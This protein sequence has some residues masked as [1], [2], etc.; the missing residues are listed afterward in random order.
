MTPVSDG[1]SIRWSQPW[2]R[3]YFEAPLLALGLFAL[4]SAVQASAEPAGSLHEQP[5]IG[6]WHL[7]IHYQKDEGPNRDAWRWDDRVWV[8]EPRETLDKIEVVEPGPP[9]IDWSEHRLVNFHDKTGRFEA[10]RGGTLRVL[11]AWTPNAGQREEIETG[12]WV[13]SRGLRHKILNENDEAGWISRLPGHPQGAGVQSFAYVE[14]WRLRMPGGLPEFRQRGKLESGLS[15]EEALDIVY[16]VEEILASGEMR[17]RVIVE[18]YRNARFRLARTRLLTQPRSRDSRFVRQEAMEKRARKTPD[19]EAAKVE[20]DDG[21][22]ETI[23]L[24][25]DRHV[26][27]S[28]SLIL[29]VIRPW[30]CFGD[31]V[32]RVT[33]TPTGAEV[34]LSYVRRGTLLLYHS[35]ETPVEVQ[36]PSRITT[37][38]RDVVIIR[39]FH[40]GYERLEMRVPARGVEED[41]HFDLQPLENQVVKVAHAHLLGRSVFEITTSQEPI[42]R[43]NTGTDSHSV[44]IL[45][46]GLDA[47]IVRHLED[48][49]DPL[50]E[51]IQARQLADDLV[52][53]LEPAAPTTPSDIRV[54]RF[55]KPDATRDSYR[56]RVEF[57]RMMH[58]KPRVAQLKQALDTLAKAKA[59]PC[60]QVFEDELRG[61]VPQAALQ[62]NLAVHHHHER[63]LLR[64][65]LRRYASLQTPPSITTLDGETL[66]TG[67]PIE[68][69]MAVE[70]A[71][72]IH[73]FIA[74]LHQLA[75]LLDPTNEGAGAF[76]G[77]VLPDQAMDSF[78]P[79]YRDARQAEQRCRHERV[80]R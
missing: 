56:T 37:S 76:H 26:Q 44:V 27:D 41:I 18:G 51:T 72:E 60:D 63:A 75:A 31:R 15:E 77:L 1:V 43:F 17:G 64:E 20:E 49:E 71:P 46:T 35:G 40:A 34:G 12:L 36:I 73:G 33:T 10:V 58:E 28:T 9:A 70:H 30:H 16:R 45:R 3:T 59:D 13:S 74:W 54:R 22:P 65:A 19:A 5:F 25:P 11:V 2:F 39:A 21:D 38:D 52:M 47:E 80:T 23:E 78:A 24:I 55:V 7:L 4:S 50:F 32:F 79:I 48:V 53:R 29:S 42:L 67:H 6:T 66:A 14:Q 69:E 62:Q 8:I 68:F 61:E 57:V